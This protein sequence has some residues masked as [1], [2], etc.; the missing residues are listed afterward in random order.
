MTRSRILALAFGCLVAG[1]I[2]YAGELAL[3]VT[4]PDP[5]LAAIEA[6]AAA[7]RPW[8]PRTRREVV[9]DLRAKGVQA[10]PRIVPAG[11]L[12]EEVPGELRSRLSLEGRELLPLAGIS[13]RTTVLCNETGS[14]AV[15]ESDEHGFRNPPGSWPDAATA[16]PVE[17]LLLGD[18]FTMGE[19]VAPG[20][21]VAERLRARLP[22][23]LDLGYSGN[24]PLL[25]LATLVEYGPI[26]R[27]RIVLWLY[28]EN[29]LSWFDLGRSSRS[30]LL[31]RY[32]EPGFQQGLAS[33]QPQIDGLLEELL[34][35]RPEEPGRDGPWAR[36]E[37]LESARSL[38]D[39]LR[40][41]QLRRRLGAL[42]GARGVPR[43]PPDYALFTRILERAAAITAGWNGRLALVYLPGVWNFDPHASGPRFADPKARERLRGIAGSLGLPFVDVHGAFEADPDPLG[44]Y[45]YRGESRVGSPHMN[46]RGYALVAH[47]IESSL[48]ESLPQSA[49]QSSTR[50]SQISRQ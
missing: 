42:R 25:E 50:S 23:T 21:N 49:R 36:L 39:F 18:S 6:A 11:L 22:R 8:D 35:A 43:E 44:L 14:W 5:A 37:E 19:C 13:R 3:R 17:L 15:F 40:L 34:A 9:E 47:T 4:R 2:L 38:G 28:F 16:A 31:M 1:A 48:P 27:P 12:E 24:S 30:P 46:A 33:L 45:S 26:L 29:D 32:L 10:V 7:G 20:D 41:E